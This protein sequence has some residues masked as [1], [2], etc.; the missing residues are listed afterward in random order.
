M[1]KVTVI[2]EQVFLPLLRQFIVLVLIIEFY[3]DDLTNIL[4]I[5]DLPHKSKVSHY[6]RLI[7]FI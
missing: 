7:V 2:A 3:F 5:F 1:I 6:L 4:K